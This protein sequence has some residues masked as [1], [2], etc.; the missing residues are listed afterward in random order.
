MTIFIKGALLPNGKRSNILIEDNKISAMGKGV[1]DKSDVVIDGKELAAIPGFFNMHTHAAMSLLKGFADDFELHTWLT[2]YIFPIEAKMKPKHV[3]YG[4]MLACAEMIRSGT[5]CFNDMYFFEE[6][7]AKAASKAGLRAI[8]SKVITNK[9]NE[10]DVK[11][12]IN[13]LGRYKNIIPALGPHAIYTTTEDVLLGA[14]SLSEELSVPI[15]FH[16]SETQK[17]V[18]DCLKEKN[19]RPVEYLAHIGFLNKNLFN[20]HCVWLNEKEIKLLAKNCAKAISC[21][22]SNL[23]LASGIAPLKMLLDNKVLLMLGTDGSASNN[24]LNM[25]EAMKFASLLQKHK[26]NDASVLN[27]QCTFK[28][29]NINAAEALNI[30]CGKLFVGCLADISL[31]DL[32]HISMVPCHN[33]LSN[34]VYSAEPN[35][36]HTVICDGEILMDAR[37]ISWEDKIKKKASKEALKLAKH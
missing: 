31:I 14:K 33:L 8:I 20:A 17:E 18:S 26:Q 22:T 32:N 1:I 35:A 19:M 25:F 5:T 16:L 12:S 34:I 30:D 21:P 3:Y 4:T 29:S 28:L 27:A 11:K 37:V 23:K 24:S 10:S 13:V 9:L 2:E 6:E 7:G 36:V 15:H